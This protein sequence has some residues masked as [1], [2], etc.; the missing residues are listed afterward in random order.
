MYALLHSEG[1]VEY[2]FKVPVSMNALSSREGPIKSI[3]NYL[4]L[5]SSGRAMD[6]FKVDI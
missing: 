4:D 6:L 1:P 5:K 3:F 2:I